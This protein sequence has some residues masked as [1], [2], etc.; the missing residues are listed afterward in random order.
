MPCEFLKPEQRENSLFYR[1]EGEAAERHGIIGYLRGDYGKSGNEFWT[2][3]FD[4]QPHLKTS[5]FKQEFNSIMDY[6]RD[7]SQKANLDGNSEFAA[8]CL[9]NMRRPVTDTAVRFKIQTEDYSYYVRC[10]PRQS[11][12]DFYC[13][14]YDN[15]FLLPEL[16]GKYEL[17][18]FCYSTASATDAIIVIR[19][20]ERGYYPCEYSTN[21]PEYNQEF[22][23]DRNIKLGVTRAQEEAML[24]G[25]L[26]GKWDISAA[27]P[28]HYDERGNPRPQ[29]K[30]NEPER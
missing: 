18:D 30:K 2:T 1:M 25:S 24:A 17:P 26:F 11:D 5:A 3:W 27:K 16:A 8:H 4:N 6:L 14:A 21:D 19:R 15:R 7:E 13:M 23:R 20:G 28:W 9:K 10:H 12:Y 22:A 29:P